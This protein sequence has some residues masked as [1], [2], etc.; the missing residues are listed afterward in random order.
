MN[1]ASAR[2]S[3]QLKLKLRPSQERT[4]GRWLFR[5]TGAWN[6]TVTKIDRESARGVYPSR[7][8]LLTQVS[9][10]GRKI[11]VAQD[12]LSGIVGDAHLA[13]QRC[14]Q[15]L[16]RRPRMK[17][18]RRRLNS[19]P[20][21]H[22]KDLKLHDRS[23]SVPVIGRLKFHAQ[24]IPEGRI[25]EGRLIKRASGWYLRLVIQADRAPIAA[26]G[27]GAIG[28]DPGF[29][30]L[31]TL[32]SGEIV[33]H[34]DELRIGALRLAQAQR[35]KR[36][37]LA[38]RLSERQ[39]NRRKDRNHKLSLRLVAENALIA[40]SKDRT[41]GVAAMF[42][43]SVSSAAHHQ[44]RRMLIDKSRAG[45]R[46]FLEVPSRNS[47]RRCSACWALTGPTGL[48]SLSVRRWQCAACGAGHDRDCN[49][50]INT[51]N[52]ALGMSVECG[53]E[54]ALGIAT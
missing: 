31:L 40:W 28:I 34:P 32:S 26:T 5:L 52:V 13:W 50:A 6:W 15:G 7:F 16:S 19:I 14:F 4:L 25:G 17:G 48:A 54:A 51:L 1:A 53:R 43:K 30:R 36:T 23:V 41:R 18:R 33:E 35:G 37:R 3:V 46:Q 20:F 8:D 24:E 21:P 42:G 38:A 29:S 10:H 45:G 47:T 49:A 2:T 27:H 9:G 11:G 22:G 44:L 39:A 12:A